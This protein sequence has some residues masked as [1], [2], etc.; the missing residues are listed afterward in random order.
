MQQF[1]QTD[2]FQRCINHVDFHLW[3][4]DPQFQTFQQS[5]STGGMGKNGT[6]FTC[7]FVWFTVAPN[8]IGQIAVL[9]HKNGVVVMVLQCILHR[10]GGQRT[11]LWASFL[12]QTFPPQV[13]QGWWQW[14]VF[15]QFNF[16]TRVFVNQKINHIM[17]RSDFFGQ[18]FKQIPGNQLHNHGRQRCWTISIVANHF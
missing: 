15:T 2:A 7:A 14:Y 6:A 8:I 11:G 1:Q 4:A 16:T 10:K 17:K 12:Q 3:I 18:F 9:F 13:T 5:Q